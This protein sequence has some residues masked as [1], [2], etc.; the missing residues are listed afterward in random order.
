MFAMF[1][2]KLRY[3]ISILINDKYRKF[4]QIIDI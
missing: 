2:D 4:Q 1:I 3:G